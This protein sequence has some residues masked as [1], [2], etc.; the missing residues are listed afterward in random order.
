MGRSNG[1]EANRKRADAKKRMEKAMG[2]GAS[3]QLK[4]NEKAQSL[5]CK[6]CMQ[7]FMSTQKSQLPAH[8]DSKHPKLKWADCFPDIPDPRSEGL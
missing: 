2:K 1:C 5:K 7:T 3:S 8:V 4:A 6:I